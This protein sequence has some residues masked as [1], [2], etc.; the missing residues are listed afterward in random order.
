MVVWAFYL[1]AITMTALRNDGRLTLFVGGLAMLQYAAIAVAVF[2]LCI[3]P[4]N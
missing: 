3:R 1:I 4:S 2:G